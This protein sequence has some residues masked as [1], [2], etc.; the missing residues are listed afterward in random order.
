MRLW[1]GTRVPRKTGVPPRISGSLW[2]TVCIVE[3]SPLSIASGP[4]SLH[5]TPLAGKEGSP[6]RARVRRE[7]APS[8]L[9]GAHG[10]IDPRPD[11][12]SPLERRHPGRDPESPPEPGPSVRLDLHAHFPGRGR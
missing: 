8:L 7:G 12:G 6:I 5:G 9:G 2:I 4:C 1:T 10:R 11:P 3:I